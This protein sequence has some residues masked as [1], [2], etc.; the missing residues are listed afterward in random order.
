MYQLLR[1]AISYLTADLHISK[2][3]KRPFGR[4][5]HRPMKDLDTEIAESSNTWFED[6][7]AL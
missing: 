6:L 4:E 7:N 3:A 5:Q 1:M 2:K